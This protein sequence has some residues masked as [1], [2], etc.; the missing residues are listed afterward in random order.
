MLFTKK[1][2]VL[3]GAQENALPLFANGKMSPP[4]TP[5]GTESAAKGSALFVFA[6]VWL[7]SMEMDI[8]AMLK[9]KFLNPFFGNSAKHLIFW[10]Q[11]INSKKEK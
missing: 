1:S 3:S 2:V 7:T 5:G 11:V 6:K 9:S 8:C 4:A 10:L